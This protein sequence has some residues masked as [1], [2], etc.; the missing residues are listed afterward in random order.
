MKEKNKQKPVYK[1]MSISVSSG[2]MGMVMFMNKQLVLLKSSVRASKSP[3]Q[4]AKQVSVWIGQYN[5]DCIVTEQLDKQSR[6]G[7]KTPELI[8]C[9]VKTIQDIPI[10]HV[11][12]KRQQSHSNKYKEAKALVN[13]HL[14]LKPYLQPKRNIWQS[15]NRRMMLF[16]AVSNAE[17]II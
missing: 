11:E 5:P 8:A 16:E 15:E 17:Q 14:Q 10:L 1:T 12:V 4:A 3:Q 13:R 7:G 6:K 9:M 2:K